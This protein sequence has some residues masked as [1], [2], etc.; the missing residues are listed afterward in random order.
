MNKKK[1]LELTQSG[2]FISGI[3]NYCDRW[4]EKCN[5]TKKC[6]NFH[7]LN[8]RLAKRQNTEEDTM[9]D[10]LN[11]VHESFALAH[12]MINDYME[13]ENIKLD[14]EELD[15]IGKKEK[16]I[17]N[18]VNQNKIIVESKNYFKLVL[19]FFE[20]HS[21]YFGQLMNK[22]PSSDDEEAVKEHEA[23]EI[24][25]QYQMLIYTKLARAI[26][27][28]YE[29]EDNWDDEYDDK[30]VSARIAI[31]SIEKSI[32]SWQLIHDTYPT[33]EEEARAFITMLNKIKKG[34]EKLL[35][36]V[37]NYRRPYFD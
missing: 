6:L 7:V 37:V 13:K 28:L 26:H 21:F 27:E 33:Y 34:A 22:V 12:E 20:R 16:K 15:E 36:K 3:F 17:F 32:A 25:M 4:C 2:K 24:I 35:P 5:Y 11:D 29:D 8:E 18:K 10:A 9:Q 14:P 30:L 23:V 1:L 19:A 31:V